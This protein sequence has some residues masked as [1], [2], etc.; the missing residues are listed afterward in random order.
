MAVIRGDFVHFQIRDGSGLRTCR[1]SQA[2][3]LIRERLNMED[4]SVEIV[5]SIFAKHRREIERIAQAMAS[6]SPGKR[7][8]II[9]T[10][11]EFND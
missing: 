4:G 5:L 10:T 6:E 3:L 9:I 2:A 1:I 7:G 8:R 11:A